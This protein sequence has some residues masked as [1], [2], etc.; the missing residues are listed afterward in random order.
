MVKETILVLILK[1]DNFKLKKRKIS[2]LDLD[3]PLFKTRI[4]L[5]RMLK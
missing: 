1:K 2:I 5:N 4:I 3:T